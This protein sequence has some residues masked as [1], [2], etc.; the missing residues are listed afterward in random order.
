M[1]KPKPA[2]TTQVINAI[3]FIAV[4]LRR[5]SGDVAASTKL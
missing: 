5:R 1:M 3:H 2:V 4:P